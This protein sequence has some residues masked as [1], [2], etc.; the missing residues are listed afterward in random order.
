MARILV[1]D[2]EAELRTLLRKVLTRRGHEVIEAEN[3]AIAIA[4]VEEGEKLDMI[5]TDIFMPET[6]GIE[7]L[8]RLRAGHP[9]LK[10]VVMS[11]GGNRVSRGYLPAATALGA[12]HVIEKPFDLSAVGDQIENLLK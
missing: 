8:R 12:D 6:D 10:I 9:D 11:G 5:I 3:G 1:V 2:D 7:V 4:M